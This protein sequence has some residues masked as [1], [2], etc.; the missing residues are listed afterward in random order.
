MSP[1]SLTGFRCTACGNPGLVA[2][3]TPWDETKVLKGA[4]V[5]ESCAATFDVI[6]GSPFFGHYEPDDVLGLIEIAANARADNHY[7]DRPTSDRIEALLERYDEASDKPAFV[8]GSSDAYASAPWFMNRYSEYR[9]FQRVSRGIDLS[10]RQILDAGAGTGFDA[11]RL[12]RGGG[13]VTAIEYNPVLVRRGKAVAHEARWVG[14]FSHVLPFENATF[15]IV[16]CNAALHHMRD[17]PAAIQEMLRVLRPGGWLLTTGDPFRSD[18]YGEDLE[19]EV[20]DRHPAVLLGVNERIPSF[21][22]LVRT[23]IRNHDNV[24]AEFIVASSG[25]AIKA[26]VRQQLQ[27]GPRNQ[28][29]I[30]VRAG[31]FAEV[32]S[33]Y[34]DAMA[35]LVPLLPDG[36]FDRAFP[37]RRQSRFDLLNGWR[38][39]LPGAEYRTF[40][41]RARWFLTHRSGASF[42]R[43]VVRSEGEATHL[44]VSISGHPAT[45]TTRI[46][47][48]GWTEVRV[49]LA[50]MRP[51]TRFACEMESSVEGGDSAEFDDYVVRVRNLGLARAAESGFMT[52]IRWAASDIFH[53]LRRRTV[54]GLG[55]RLARLRDLNRGWLR[56]H[57]RA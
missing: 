43:V 33:D 57:R 17:V 28:R 48:A 22:D 40:Y 25:L 9:A 44:Q 54:R 10:G 41:K 42:V 11:L 8:A 29:G 5:C 56:R 24:D 20:F 30:A 19:F 52:K 1:S 51:G 3:G 7:G 55:D 47:P 34:A 14:G 36:L 16:C 45:I 31:A 32:L 27:V 12:I 4:I 38:R 46:T 37:G 2:T 13:H 6:W 23:V 26:R 39:P 35:A 50:G 53:A 18:L 21:D 15:D 49:P